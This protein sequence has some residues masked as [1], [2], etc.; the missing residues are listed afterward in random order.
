MSA[1]SLL[2]AWAWSR[3]LARV[4]R[5][6]KKWGYGRVGMALTAAISAAM[7]SIGVT[8]WSQPV[9]DP[10]CVPAGQKLYVVH[11]HGCFCLAA[12]LNLSGEVRRRGSPWHGVF[13]GVADVLFKMPLVREFLLLA[14]CRPANMR[15]IDTLLESG[16]TVALNPGGIHEQLATDH[17]RERIFFPAKL[18]FV[19][20]AIKHGVPLVPVYDFGENQLFR[21]PE[22]SRRASRSLKA[23]TGAG[24]PFPVGR[25]GLPFVPRRTHV[26]TYVGS[27]VPVGPA[28]P[29]PSEARVQAV[30][31]AYC[32]A[33]RNLFDAHKD[34]ALPADV[35]ARGIELIWR[36]HDAGVPALT[37]PRHDRPEQ[38]LSGTAP[39]AGERDGDAVAAKFASKL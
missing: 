5:R 7:G 19:R 37:D 34:D 21:V 22:W 27:A 24:V 36:G 13:V 39:V 29:N 20:Q 15:M 35:A 11:P 23:A 25:F 16:E 30:F 1:L 9:D 8:G 38:E 2:C 6:P 33:L 14:N 28:D 32:A 4:V 10:S 3:Y 12:V 31:S 17:K 18:G 26:K